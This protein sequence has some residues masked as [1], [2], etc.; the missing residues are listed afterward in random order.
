M[1]TSW[2]WRCSLWTKPQGLAA[3]GNTLEK[4]QESAVLAANQ[5]LYNGFLAAGPDLGIVLSGS[6]PGAA[7]Q[8]VLSALRRSS[9]EL[10][11]AYSTGATKILYIQAAPAA[12]R[13]DRRSGW[14][15]RRAPDV[16]AVRSRSRRRSGWSMGPARRKPRW[17]RIVR[18]GATRALVIAS[19]GS[20]ARIGERGRRH[21]RARRR[22]ACMRKR[23]C[24]C[25]ARS[26]RRRSW[27]RARRTGRRAH[28]DRRRLADRTCE[29]DRA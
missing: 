11:G 28:R 29:S 4:A 6:R 7:H 14:R 2:C 16:R 27:R 8:D 25:R 1:P 3:F 15:G 21:P 23:C 10:Y 17:T 24:M 5:G 22:Q 19:P 18:L 26:S 13:A 9:P 20:G 12:A